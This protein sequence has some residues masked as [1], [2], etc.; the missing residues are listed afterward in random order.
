MN[1]LTHFF[2]LFFLSNLVCAQTV[3][4]PMEYGKWCYSYYDE[5]NNQYYNWDG[6]IEIVG[7][8]IIDNT[9]YAFAKGDNKFNYFGSKDTYI[10]REENHRVYVWNAVESTEHLVYDFNL[11]VQDT[12]V[13]D[14]FWSGFGEQAS[15]IVNSIDTV[16]GIDGLE[17]KFYYL[18]SEENS[19]ESYSTTWI[20]GIGDAV[21]PFFNP[22]YFEGTSLSGGYYFLCYSDS[23][24]IS[25]LNDSVSEM[26]C[27]LAS[28]TLELV[29]DYKVTIYPNP[30]NQSI[31]ISSPDY[32]IDQVNIYDLNGTLVY[33]TSVN[34]YE[35]NIE[36]TSYINPG[37]Y[38]CGVT[39]KNNKQSFQ[40]I[41]LLP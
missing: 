24:G 35:V 6:C 17:R 32:L 19:Q 21:W 12:F 39:T 22:N 25:Y 41:I 10:F 26:D 27:L 29:L 40:K 31:Q 37:I 30:T 3:S 16:L 38:Y 7:D 20:E 36:L 33:Y 15:M 34:D 28:P 1:R 2:I 4:F 5:G 9:I 8:T 11:N 13:G 14:F 23:L 18:S